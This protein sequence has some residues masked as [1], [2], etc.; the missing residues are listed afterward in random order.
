MYNFSLLLM[1]LLLL[2]LLL[3]SSSLS[4]LLLLLLLLLLVHKNVSINFGSSCTSALN[5]RQFIRICFNL[6]TNK[7]VNRKTL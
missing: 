6:L 1:L 2:L 4:L 7:S 5:Y 3:S